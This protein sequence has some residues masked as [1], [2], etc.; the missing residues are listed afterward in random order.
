MHLKFV[1]LSLFYF[2]KIAH[3]ILLMVSGLSYVRRYASHSISIY[4]TPTHIKRYY[5]YYRY[6]SCLCRIKKILIPKTH[7]HCRSQCKYS[8]TYTYDQSSV[9]KWKIFLILCRPSNAIWIWS[10]SN[11]IFHKHLANRT[12]DFYGSQLKICVYEIIS[13]CID[14]HFFFW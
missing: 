14:K 12:K 2:Y 6:S 8:V 4:A 9:L 7:R 3:H 10:L 1:S 13:K 5:R 11:A